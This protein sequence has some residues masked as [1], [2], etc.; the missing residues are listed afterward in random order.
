M[1]PTFC[2]QKPS[3]FAKIVELVE[4]YVRGEIEQEIKDKQ[5]CYHNLDH[6]LAVKRRANII[7]NAIKPILSTE[8]RVEE[9]QRLE[10][11]INLCALAHDMVQLFD[12]SPHPHQPRKH[13]MGVSETATAN[14]L[15]R[16]IRNLNQK[17]LSYNLDAALLFSDR[18]Q[19]IIQDAIR[20]TICHQDPQAG[21]ASYTFSTN[22]IYQP[23]LYEVR[24]KISIA[25]SIIA[26]ADLGTLGIDGINK[27]IADGIQIFQENN[28]DYEFLLSNYYLRDQLSA[29]DITVANNLK[30][31][32][33]AMT[34]LMVS[35]AQERHARLELEISGFSSPAQAILRQQI[36]IYLNQETIEEIK[37]IIPTQ[38][39]TSLEELI[40][41]FRCHK[42]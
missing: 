21:K 13:L 15:L 6:A 7:F 29:A 4:N 14:K 19:Q 34:R 2:N 27:Y 26:L 8:Y 36:F 41:F 12:D 3:S 1:K 40:S 28:L 30:A 33:L 32:L 42:I 20:A 22:S 16:Y 39:N 31:R 11:L 9:L 38:D 23:Y 17:L 35:F 18:D 5:L 37:T 24:P 10:S 25:G